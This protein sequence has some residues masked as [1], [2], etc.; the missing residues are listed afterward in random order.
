VGLFQFEKQEGQPFDWETSDDTNTSA[1]T[2]NAIVGIP[3]D[4]AAMFGGKANLTPAGGKSIAEGGRNNELHRRGSAMR[5]QGMELE[6]IAG[7]L[8]GLNQEVCKPPLPSEEV[9]GIASSV[10][11]YEAGTV[12]PAAGVYQAKGDIPKSFTE[13][14]IAEAIAKAYG[15]SCHYIAESGRWFVCSSNGLWIEDID[16]QI[17]RWIFGLLAYAKER[18]FDLFRIGDESRRGMLAQ[19][20]KTDKSHAL[21]GIINLLSA[22]TGVTVRAAILDADIH[23]VGLQ[24]GKL[25]D[26]KTGQVRDILPSDYITKTLGVV[27]DAGAGCPIWR[28]CI[29]E[30]TCGDVELAAFLQVFIGYCLSGETTFQGFLFLHGGGRNGKSIFVQIIESLLGDYAKTL[31]PEA[32]MLK[33]GDSGTNNE[34]ARL[35]GARFVKSVEL[36]E[37]RTLNENLVKQMVG[38]DTLTARFLYGEWF[39]LKPAFKL[40]I[41]GNHRPIVRGTDD[42]IWRRVALVPFNARI[43][44]PDPDLF[45]KLKAELPGILNWALDGWKVYQSQGIRLPSAVEKESKAYRAES[46]I[47]GRFLDERCKIDKPDRDTTAK[48]MFS[49]FQVWAEESGLRAGSS[50]SFGRRMEGRLIKHKNGNGLLFIRCLS[51]LSYGGYRVRGCFALLVYIEIFPF[52]GSTPYLHNLLKYR[53]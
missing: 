4:L 26:L 1:A 5:G 49:A 41:V 34:I 50:I 7:E 20:L 19:V 22:L 44:K 25:V 35:A 29:D 3:D 8:L 16:G 52:W 24:G 15:G 39:E 9:L 11:R 48:N 2:S 6:E 38:G 32:L 53:R 51:V 37:E 36:P 33:H 13:L 21:N 42:G 31:N 47:V 18:A 27:F 28:R 10:C 30:W 43:D 17:K 12:K 40:V 45:E 14:A 23:K 46:D